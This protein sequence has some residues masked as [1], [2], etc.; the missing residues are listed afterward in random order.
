MIKFSQIFIFKILT[1]KVLKKIIMV[2]LENPFRKQLRILYKIC[3]IT[4][5]KLISNLNNSLSKN[6]RNPNKN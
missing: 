6:N 3:K 4:K 1:M 5:K 2:N